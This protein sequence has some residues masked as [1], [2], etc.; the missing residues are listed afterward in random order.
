MKGSVRALTAILLL[1]LVAVLAILGT[2]AFHATD[3]VAGFFNMQK[4]TIRLWYSDE[5]LSD[6]LNIRAVAYNETHDDVRIEPVHVS[7]VEI[8]ENIYSTSLY[9]DVF[10]DLYI[11]TNDMLEKAH[12]A[13]L[14]SDVALSGSPF[15]PNDFPESAR[16]AVTYQGRYVAY[17][18]YYETSV[19]MYNKTYLEQVVRQELGVSEDADVSTMTTDEGVPMADEI[20]ARIS[21][22]I[23]RTIADLLKFSSSYNAPATVEAVF[24]WDVTDVFY[25][26]FFVGAYMNAGGPAG[27]DIASLN[28]Y[29][30]EMV[31]CMK[32]YQKLNTYFA[33]D[34]GSVNYESIIED[35]IAG[36]MLFTVV[37]S[38]AV[39]RITKAQESGECPY[40]YGAADIPALNDF[41]DTRTMSVTDCVVINGYS[42]HV[43]EAADF[44]EF[45]V[46]GTD[47]S[48]FRQ[49]GKL[50]AR[51]IPHYED[52]R[53][54]VFFDVYTAS[55]P[56][57]K[58]IETSNLWMRLE[59]AFTQIWNG[60]DSNQT[61]KEMSES[62]MKQVVGR[63]YEEMLLPEPDAVSI[64]DE[65]AGD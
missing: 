48:I 30:S 31:S 25:N 12:L 61:L 13:G 41:Y 1:I 60:A 62:M 14:T 7:G 19:L 46:S 24:K 18:F 52:E 16:N 43:P 26:Y 17:P 22:K 58:M 5:A 11:V 15:S 9:E 39:T 47:E 20:E 21:E 29:N 35:F 59:I 8:L 64:T 27:D 56:M 44:A 2:G 4:T 57:P 3:T 65:T 51:T 53:L 55:V 40:E 37:T 33:I 36:K 6:Y 34:A 49:T 50:P 23:P 63:H 38:D 54:A 28:L 10:P 45:L 32:A 42:E